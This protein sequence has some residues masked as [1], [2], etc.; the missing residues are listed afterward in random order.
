[1]ICS[2]LCNAFIF[3]YSI[4]VVNRLS[5]EHVPCHCQTHCSATKWNLRPK[6]C[7][8]TDETRPP[9]DQPQQI[10][11]NESGEPV[12]VERKDT[13]HTASQWAHESDGYMYTRVP[14]LMQSLGSSAGTSVPHQSPTLMHFCQRYPLPFI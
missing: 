10:W 6:H 12:T 14:H 13:T 8:I 7:T 3:I 1:M 11:Q 9:P 4:W 5:S 2:L